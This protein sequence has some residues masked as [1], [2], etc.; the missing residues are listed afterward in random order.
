MAEKKLVVIIE[1]TAAMGPFWK[2]IL[3]DYLEEIVRYGNFLL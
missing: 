3:S 1:G 2:S